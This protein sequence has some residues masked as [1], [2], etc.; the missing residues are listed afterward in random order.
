[1]T[2][3]NLADPN[4]EPTDD[5]LTELSDRAFADVAAKSAEAHTKL[6]LEIA[7]LSTESLTRLKAKKL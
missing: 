2:R 5:E 6:K 7:R 3:P 4:V 1:M